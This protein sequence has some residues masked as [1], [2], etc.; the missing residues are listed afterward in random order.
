MPKDFDGLGMRQF[1][2]FNKAML[3]KAT[4]DILKQPTTLWVRV[5]HRKFFITSHCLMFLLNLWI[6]LFGKV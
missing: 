5:F 4:W 6:L 3:E 1:E 2:N